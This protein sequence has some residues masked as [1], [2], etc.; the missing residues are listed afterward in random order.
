M[1]PYQIF[2]RCL[3]KKIEVGVYAIQM[4]NNANFKL[5]LKK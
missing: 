3:A 2:L 5:K 4:C 1:L